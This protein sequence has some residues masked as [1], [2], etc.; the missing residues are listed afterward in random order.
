MSHLKKR[1][2]TTHGFNVTDQSLKGRRE[3][4]EEESKRIK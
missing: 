1:G 3:V 4:L 2:V